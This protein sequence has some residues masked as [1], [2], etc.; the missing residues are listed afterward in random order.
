MTTATLSKNTKP[1]QTA[2]KST[3]ESKTTNARGNI[4]N[5]FFDKNGQ[6]VWKPKAETTAVP[7]S[8]WTK[9]EENYTFTI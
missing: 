9:R 1:K 4:N 5:P 7:N 2:R 8:I 3:S 6:F